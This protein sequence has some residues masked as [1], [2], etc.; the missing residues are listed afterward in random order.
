M[1]DKAFGQFGNLNSHM[2]V[3]T[4]DNSLCLVSHY[5]YLLLLSV[6]FLCCVVNI[7]MTGVMHCNLKPLNL[8]PKSYYTLTLCCLVD[9]RDVFA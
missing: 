4:E 8:Q 2:R 6:S 5:M 7:K 3:H 9:F 1:C